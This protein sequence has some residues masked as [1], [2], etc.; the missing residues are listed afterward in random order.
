[1]FNTN[2]SFLI[3]LFEFFLFAG[4]MCLFGIMGDIFRSNDL[5]AVARPLWVLFVIFIPWMGIL[6]YLI[7]RGKGIRDRQLE[8]AR[9][10]QRAQT[11]SIQ[12]AAGR[13]PHQPRR[14][15]FLRQEP[16]R[17]RGDHPGR[18]RDA[19]GGGHRHLINGRCP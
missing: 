7:G 4:F 18:V 17:P 5:G 19:Q 3:A 8:R 15:D 10:I 13:C 2:G 9:R 11:E 16:A 6:V 1:M 12:S 14:P